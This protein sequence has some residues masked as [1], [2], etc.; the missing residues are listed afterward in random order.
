MFRLAHISDVHL[1]PLPDVTYR[2]LA[3]KRIT[4]YVNWHRNRASRLNVGALGAIVADMLASVP[5]HIAVTGDLMNLALEVEIELAREWLASLGEPNSVSVVPGN[6]DA[7]VPGALKKACIAWRPWTAGETGWAKA[8]EHGF[9]YIRVRDKVAIIG[10]SSARASAPFLA[11]GS[12]SAEQAGRLGRI[13]DRAGDEGLFRV[14]MIHHPPVRGAAPSH[15]RLYGIGTFQDTLRRHGAELVL[16]GHTHLPTLYWIG[17]RGSL[18]PVVGV[19]AGGE[20]HGVEKPLAQY[21]LLEISGQAGDWTVELVR[22][23]LT[24]QTSGVAQLSREPLVPPG[25]SRTAGNVKA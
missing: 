8:N 15:K 9:P 16:H 22:H 13:L 2:E 17:G 24:G 5:D 11:T 18:V 25:V 21:N 3:S 20:S 10:V 12:F 6:H 23:G 14:I 4:G 7:Y 1:G 19:A